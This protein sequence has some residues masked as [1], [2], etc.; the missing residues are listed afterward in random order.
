MSGRFERYPVGFWRAFGDWKESGQFLKV[1]WK[2]SG[3]YKIGLSDQII[4]E[5]T[6]GL[7]SIT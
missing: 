3:K 7:V 4:L 6:A 5:C 2:V 1:I